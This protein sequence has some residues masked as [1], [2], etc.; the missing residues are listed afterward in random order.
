MRRN[1]TSRSEPPRAGNPDLPMINCVSLVKILHARA[2]AR[3]LVAKNVAR[4]FCDV[5][6]CPRKE[7]RRKRC[8]RAS[9]WRTLNFNTQ[10]LSELAKADVMA[11][12]AALNVARWLPFALVAI[13]KMH[14]NPSTP[15]SSIFFVSSLS[16]CN[17]FFSFGRR[18]SHLFLLPSL[19]RRVDRSF[20]YLLFMSRRTPPLLSVLPFSF[21]LPASPLL[22]YTGDVSKTKEEGRAFSSLFL[23]SI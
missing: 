7:E 20:G 12:R 18:A 4:A 3:T 2:R 8:T 16:G 9:G 23:F 1:K 5:P 17:R 15:A 21:D 19:F 13:I 22:R 11:I 14:Y 6:R 10:P